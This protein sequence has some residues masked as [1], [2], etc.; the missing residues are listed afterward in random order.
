M[1]IVE[2]PAVKVKFQ[3]IRI[4]GPVDRVGVLPAFQVPLVMVSVPPTV[5]PAVEVTVVPA[6]PLLIVRL[7]KFCPAPP[8]LA[9]VAPVRL[10]VLLAPVKVATVK[11]PVTVMASVPVAVRVPVPVRLVPTVIAEPAQVERSV[12]G[13]VTG[14]LHAEVEA[15]DGASA[16]GPEVVEGAVVFR[17][18]RAVHDEQG[19]ALLEVAG[20]VAKVPAY[21]ELV[22]VR[23]GHVEVAPVEVQV[24]ADHQC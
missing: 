13:A 19:G 20:A 1:T 16:G 24:A 2:S 7:L 11:L 8:R 17:G 12:D 5:M 23:K 6:A 18:A 3:S 10:T 15:G 14:R 21:G 4:P 9:A 22:V